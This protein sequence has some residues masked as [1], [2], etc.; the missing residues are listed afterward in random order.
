MIDKKYFCYEIYKNL[1]VWSINGKLGYN[2]CSFFN[3]YIKTNDQFNLSDIWN[4]P[5]HL[6]LK[7]QVENDIP[8]AGCQGCYNE[9]AGGLTSRRMASK[10]CMKNFIMM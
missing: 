7:H 5:E 1:A 4:S 10:N 8:I 6:Q 3:G 9:E 2:P